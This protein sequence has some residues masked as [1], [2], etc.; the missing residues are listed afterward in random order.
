MKKLMIITT[1]LFASF[2]IGQVTTLSEA[3]ARNS[4]LNQC[5][6]YK[7]KANAAGRAGKASEKARYWKLYDDCMR[8]RID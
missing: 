1:V 5:A 6:W 4:R 7:S 2:S 8:G 3:E